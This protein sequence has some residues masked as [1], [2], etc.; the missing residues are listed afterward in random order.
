[1]K[2]LDQT[3]SSI[4]RDLCSK[5][6]DTDYDN[7]NQTYEDDFSESFAKSDNFCCGIICLKLFSIIFNTLFMVNFHRIIF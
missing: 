5:S 4:R 1:M 6:D 7:S 3:K 2:S